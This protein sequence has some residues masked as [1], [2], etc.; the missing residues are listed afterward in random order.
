MTLPDSPLGSWHRW[1]SPTLT[2]GIPTHWSPDSSAKQNTDRL[3][4]TAV[5]ATEEAVFSAAGFKMHYA[6][7]YTDTF[8]A[9]AAEELSAIL[10]TGDPKEDITCGEGQIYRLPQVR[11][12]F[13]ADGRR[14]LLLPPIQ[15]PSGP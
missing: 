13:A 9:A 12:C 1:K 10:V 7:S 3:P 15:A 4:L 5:S 14:R 8:G 6:I 11:N 2:A